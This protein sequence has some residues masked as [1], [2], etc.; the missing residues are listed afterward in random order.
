LKHVLT[1]RLE[2]LG[3]DFDVTVARLLRFLNVPPSVPLHSELAHELRK[4][5]T[6]R[7]SLEKRSQSDHVYQPG[8][9]ADLT[10][11]KVLV[12]LWN[13]KSRSRKLAKDSAAL[14]YDDVRNSDEPGAACRGGWSLGRTQS[15]QR[16]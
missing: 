16:R 9:F 14:G 2:S 5:D 11:E 7:W 13:D 8:R 12:A 6:K 10:H 3:T 4:H 15:R 1:L